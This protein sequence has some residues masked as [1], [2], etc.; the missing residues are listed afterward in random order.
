MDPSDERSDGVESGH[1][2]GALEWI[3][4]K[5]EDFVT[6]GR[7]PLW[8]RPLLAYQRTIDAISELAGRAAL[9]LVVAVVVVGFVNAVLRYVG[10]ATGDQLSSNRYIELQWYLYATMFLLAFSY[11]LKNSI[12]VRVDFWYGD[13]SERTKAWIDLVGHLIAL[14]PFCVLAVWVVWGPVL[15][16]WGAR[17]DG[18]FPTLEVWRIWERS[19]DPGGLP[20]APIK[21]M[22]VVG[23]ALL[24]LQGVAEIIKLI[25]A[26]TG[27]G[28]HTKTVEEGVTPLRTE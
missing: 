12:N 20:R 6:T 28:R 15:T 7:P 17:P 11:I 21:T 9:Y 5:H 1:A 16:S 13:R 3:E 4:D 14:I 2:A 27:H 19:P 18:S 25:A 10:R 22:L 24:L 8:L 23:F 26:L